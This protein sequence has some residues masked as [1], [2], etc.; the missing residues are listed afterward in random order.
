MPG[1]KGEVNVKNFLLAGIALVALAAPAI[2]ADMP[3]KAPAPV[4]VDIWSGGYVGANVGYDWGR[5]I[6][7]L[8]RQSGQLQHRAGSLVA[9]AP[10]L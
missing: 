4:A 5:D 9:T 1:H 2:A 8:G 10:P 6:V 3:L 7:E